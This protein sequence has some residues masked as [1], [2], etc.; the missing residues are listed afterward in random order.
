[1]LLLLSLEATLPAYLAKR[2][3]VVVVFTGWRVLQ[4]IPKETRSEAA[5]FAEGLLV[6]SLLGWQ[7]RCCLLK[8][9]RAMVA[10]RRQSVSE[11]C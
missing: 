2:P 9:G 8:G 7:R 3:L 10:V 1:V 4:A 6:I 11:A 5:V